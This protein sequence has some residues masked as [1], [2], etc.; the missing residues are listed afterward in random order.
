MAAPRITFER[1]AG[2]RR[3]G[4]LRLADVEYRVVRNESERAWNVF[5]NGAP[6]EVSARKKKQSAVDLAIRNAIAES[7]TSEI[8]I[9]VT[10]AERRKIITVW[11]G[12]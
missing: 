1:I 3:S 10:C 8:A 9:M 4:R 12:P 7:E 6:T 5:R 2:N 11:K